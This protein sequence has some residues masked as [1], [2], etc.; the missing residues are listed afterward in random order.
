MLKIIILEFIFCWDIYIYIYIYNSLYFSRII[1]EHA[2]KIIFTIVG[3]SGNNI[4]CFQVL[5]CFWVY[6]FVKKRIRRKMSFIIFKM[7]TSRT[8]L[9]CFL[10][11]SSFLWTLF[12]FQ[13]WLS[14]YSKTS[15]AKCHAGRLHAHNAFTMLWLGNFS[16]NLILLCTQFDSK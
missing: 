9:S 4:T 12:H 13:K 5:N 1:I 11:W 15:C 10:C 3:A 14:H 8:R 7:Y 6:L 16:L 2:N